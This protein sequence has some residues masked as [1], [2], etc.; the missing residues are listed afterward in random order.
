MAGVDGSFAVVE[1]LSR[2]N[3]LHRSRDEPAFPACLAL[4][5][6]A[7]HRSI[8]ARS[9]ASYDGA[10]RAMSVPRPMWGF[11][12]F[13]RHPVKPRKNKAAMSERIDVGSCRGTFESGSCTCELRR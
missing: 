6:S 3:P 4:A 7:R 8:F 12:L 11:A 10:G 1:E 13:G 9:A 5:V 2:P